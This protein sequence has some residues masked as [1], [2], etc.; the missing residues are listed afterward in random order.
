MYKYK[1]NEEASKVSKFQEERINAF[2]EIENELETLI[3]PLRQAKIAT[4]KQYRE[5]PDSYGVVIGTDL[6][7]DYIKDIKTLLTN[8]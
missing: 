6:I 1:L 2:N 5:N 3:K 4:I 8:E 7:K